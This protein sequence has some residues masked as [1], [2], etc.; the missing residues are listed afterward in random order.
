MPRLES[1]LAVRVQ[2]QIRLR[3]D[4]V[5]PLDRHNALASVGKQQ[6]KLKLFGAVELTD[7]FQGLPLKDMRLADDL[8]PIWKWMDVG[9]VSLSPLTRSFRM[10]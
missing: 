2:P 10:C 4:R 5:C 6:Q 8:D 7:D 9:S 1:Q 3:W